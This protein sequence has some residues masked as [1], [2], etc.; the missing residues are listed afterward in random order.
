MTL[1]LFICGVCCGGHVT[2]FVLAKETTPDQYTATSLGFIN[3]LVMMSGLIAQPLLGYLLDIFWTGN[4]NP[5]GLRHY[6]ID[7]Y[8]MVFN[9]MAAVILIGALIQLFLS[10][11]RKK[12]SSKP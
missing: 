5:Q 8:H 11:P 6:T 10:E 12:E 1:V 7:T 4:I 9:L 3:C 2:A